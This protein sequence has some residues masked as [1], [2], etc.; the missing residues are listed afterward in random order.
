MPSGPRKTGI[1]DSAGL[2]LLAVAVHVPYLL[3]RPFFFADDFGLLADADN[4]TSGA[5]RFFDVP[6]WG[7]WRLGQRALWWAAY[8]LFGLDPLPYAWLSVLLHGAVVVALDALLRRLGWTRAAAF[9]AAAVFATLAA[10]ALAVRYMVQNTVLVAALFVILAAIAHD[11]GHVRGATLLFLAGALFYE[12]A[13]CA[14]LVFAAVNVWRR[15]KPLAGLAA[16]V[17]AAAAFVAVNLWTLRHAT[18]I[19]AYNTL[20]LGADALRQIVF[21]PWLAAGVSPLVPMRAST[22]ALLAAATAAILL[23]ASLRPPARGVLL[24][25]AVAW[26]AALPYLGRNVGWWP[27]YYFYLPGAGHAAAV[28][29][30]RLR[31]WPLA[32]LPLVLWNIRGDVAGGKAMLAEM[33]RYEQVTRET[34]PQSGVPYAVFVNVNSG[35]AWAGW[36]FGGSP[37]AFELWDV[38]GGPAR[39]YTGDDL[40]ATRARMLRDF[41]AASRRGRWPEDRPPALRGARPPARH[42]LFPWPPRIASY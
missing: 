25:A 42:R 33:R 19:F 10:P 37:R 8:R 38:P 36:Q 21:A 23:A 15:R 30:P 26:I 6:A 39:C 24:G 32:C 3:G 7:V 31:L 1:L 27:P 18:K 34:P 13:L 5:T 20:G 9:A 17:G 2:F 12:Q 28:S 29:A 4:L 41:P 40:D 16:P 11:A 14:P 22:A 35:L